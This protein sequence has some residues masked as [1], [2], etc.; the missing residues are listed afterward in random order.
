VSGV[1]DVISRQVGED[2]ISFGANSFVYV[3]ING[4]PRR[5]NQVNAKSIP[6][7]SIPGQKVEALI[8]GSQALPVGASNLSVLN[9]SVFSGPIY[10]TGAT[11]GYIKNYASGLFLFGAS[12]ATADIPSG[13]PASSIGSGT[14]NDAE[15]GYLNSATSNIQSQINGINS[16]ISAFNNL[17]YF[18]PPAIPNL[19]WVSTTVVKVVAAPET[20]ARVLMS[21]FPNVLNPGQFVTT[22]YNDSEYYAAT[23]DTSLTFPTNIWG[24]TAV[25]REKADQWYAVYA[26][27]AATAYILKAMPIMR[28]ASQASQ[29]ISLSKNIAPYTGIGYGFTTDELVGGSLYIISGTSAGLVRTITANNNNNAVGGTITYSGTALTMTAGDWFIVLPP[30]NFR[31]IGTVYNNAAGNID[32]FYKAGNVVTWYAPG[33]YYGASGIVEEVPCMCPLAKKFSVRAVSSVSVNTSFLI[34]HP[35]VPGPSGPYGSV[36]EDNNV[37]ID[38]VNCM[39]YVGSSDLYYWRLGYE[40]IPGCGY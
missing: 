40:Y 35:G 8:D 33:A 11:S 21:G 27:P 17:T 10:G 32:R 26:I 36:V 3:D 2:D 38:V 39:L 12:I 24:D 7:Y 29:V 22:S 19:V 30:V 28:Y 5:V 1:I 4:T 15:L 31:F 34:G 20:P 9:T 23:A 6:W 13:I 25:A 16:T 14:I 18:S 37:T